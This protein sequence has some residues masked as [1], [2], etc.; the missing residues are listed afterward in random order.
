VASTLAE[1]LPLALGAAV[2][3][4]VLL[5]QVAVLASPR[6][7][8]ARALWVLAGTALT[9]AAVMAMVI[10]GDHAAAGRASVH[11]G[12]AAVGGWIRLVLAVLLAAGA[13]RTGVA[14]HA[15]DA[16]PPPA[17]DDGVHAL[18]SLLLGVAA[19]ATNLTTIVLLIP[20]THTVWTAGLSGGNRL[21]LLVIVGVITLLPAALP[22]LLV[23]ALGRRGPVVLARVSAWL[24]QHRRTILV[25]VQVG[26]AVYFVI[27]GLRALG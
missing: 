25:V 15:D 20:A 21:A 12:A 17:P 14:P 24:Q 7:P 19:M 2:S 13:I 26:F 1:V 18:R 4:V 3:P 6:H 11:P 16:P 27:T 22:P 8:L 9:V 5:L 10:L 23:L